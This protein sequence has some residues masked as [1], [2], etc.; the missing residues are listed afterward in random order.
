MS[1]ISAPKKGDRVLND[2]DDSLKKGVSIMIVIS[3]Q[4]RYQ[5]GI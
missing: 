5:Y 2:S 1:A 4:R 3:K